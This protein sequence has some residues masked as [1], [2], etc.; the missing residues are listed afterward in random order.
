MTLKVNTHEAVMPYSTH[1][2]F[3]VCHLLLLS[4]DLS[5]LDSSWE[6]N[7]IVYNLFGLVAFGEQCFWRFPHVGACIS[8]LFLLMTE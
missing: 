7:P 2:Q 3:L 8:T 1:P 4:A 6:W 5:T